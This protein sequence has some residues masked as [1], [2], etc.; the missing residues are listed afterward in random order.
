MI[1][2]AFVWRAHERAQRHLVC[3]RDRRARKLDLIEQD[4]PDWRD[5]YDGLAS[6]QT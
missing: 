4:N 5:L 6:V 3:P 1:A 2:A